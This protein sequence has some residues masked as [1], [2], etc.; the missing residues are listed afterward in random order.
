[1]DEFERQ[2]R[3][4]RSDLDAVEDLSTQELWSG[5]EERMT[6][7]TSGKRIRGY[8]RWLAAATILLVFA[9]GLA[10]V[11]W[12]DEENLPQRLSDLSPE[13]AKQETAFLQ[14]ISAKEA[15]L[16]IEELDR[17]TFAP[18]F[19]ELTILDSIQ[20]GYLR[21][22]PEYGTNERLLNTIIRYYELK[23]QILEQ[24]ENDLAKQQYYDVSNQLL[25]I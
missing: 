19:E 8:Q 11:G 12:Q 21:E 25:E 14:T 18:F 5:I 23:I 6:G 15:A 20:A 22:L 3:R 4:H 24:L 7:R 10:Y 17:E 16:K 13:L 1:M 9:L 2:I